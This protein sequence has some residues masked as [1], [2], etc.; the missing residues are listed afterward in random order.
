MGLTIDSLIIS[1]YGIALI[2]ETSVKWDKVTHLDSG[3]RP[4]D[5]GWFIL[6]KSAEHSGGGEDFG[7]HSRVRRSR[8]PSWV[9]GRRWPPACVSGRTSRR[10]S[11]RTPPLAL[12]ASAR[13]ATTS[14][15]WKHKVTGVRRWRATSTKNHLGQTELS[16]LKDSQAFTERKSF[17]FSHM[18]DM[19]NPLACHQLAKRKSMHFWRVKINASE[20]N[21]LW[22][23]RLVC[24]LE[25]VS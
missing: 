4:C 9:G 10:L 25:D 12:A 1:Q 3:L 8:P 17:H 24:S 7:R 2:S 23:R 18:S 16:P 6:A 13:H 11:S 19:Q 21:T 15:A 20:K 14:R 22:T 5:R